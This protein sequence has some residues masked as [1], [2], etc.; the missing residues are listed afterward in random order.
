MTLKHLL[1]WFHVECLN[2]QWELRRRTRIHFWHPVSTQKAP[3]KLRNQVHNIAL[4]KLHREVSGLWVLLDSSVATARLYNL[5]LRI[6]KL[7]NVEVQ[8]HCK[9]TQHWVLNISL[10]HQDR[11][12]DRLKGLFKHFHFSRVSFR[13]IKQNQARIRLREKLHYCL[14]I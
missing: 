14:R 5:Q 2:P 12:W 8:Q 9:V 10:H 11:V 3:L 1:E 4:L 13:I 7:F 6:L